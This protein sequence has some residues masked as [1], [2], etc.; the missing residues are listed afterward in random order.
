MFSKNEFFFLASKCR[1][2]NYFANIIWLKK[3]RILVDDRGIDPHKSSMAAISPIEIS[4]S[5]S[6]F[7][8]T[9]DDEV[10]ISPVNARDSAN[11][12]TLPDWATAHPTTSRYIGR[13]H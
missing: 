11:T 2:T 7:N 1:L 8:F 10:E 9:D 3:G 13:F 4:S 6:D 5:D 12:R